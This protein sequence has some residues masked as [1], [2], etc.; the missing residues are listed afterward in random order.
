MEHGNGHAV[1]DALLQYLSPLGWELCHR[2]TKIGAGKFSHYVLS[3]QPLRLFPAQMAA[4]RTAGCELIFQEKASGGHWD[5]PELHRLLGSYAKAQLDRARPK[6]HKLMLRAA[7][8]R[9]RFWTR[10]RVARSSVHSLF[11]GSART[12][13]CN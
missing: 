2:R 10:K 3:I 5:R 13:A 11:A 7:I 1:D 6:L 8:L 4:L 12:V 9:A